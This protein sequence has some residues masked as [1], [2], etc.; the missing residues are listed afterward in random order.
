M[1]V[2]LL[3]GICLLGC[4]RR[5]RDVSAAMAADSTENAP[6][7][8][9]WSV[10]FGLQEEGLRRAHFVADRM[11]HY[12]TDDSTY[13]ELSMI[14]DSSTAERSASDS[15]D[16]P[17]ALG[18]SVTASRGRRDSLTGI[19]GGP[20][21]HDRVI[22]YVFEEGDSSAVITAERMLYFADESRFEA[23][24][25][26]MVHTVDNK[27]LSSEHLTWNQNSR[28]IRT[29]RF[30]RIITPTEDVQGNG[31]VA[32]EDLDTY[33]IGRFT[34]DVDVEESPDPDSV[35]GGGRER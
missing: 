10:H 25:D 17:S 33:Q 6:T 22:A 16:R 2:A 31:L 27:R 1:A 19:Q 8:V 3:V 35:S 15:L 13:I 4:E 28:K 29:R 30:V 34:A 32:D 14:A 20:I 9:S 26:V 23:F 5:E 11:A 12:E 7:Q 18:D 21:P 24:G